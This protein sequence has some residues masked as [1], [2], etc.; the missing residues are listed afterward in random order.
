MANEVPA[1]NKESSIAGV[2]LSIRNIGFARR[3]PRNDDGVFLSMGN[4]ASGDSSVQITVLPGF[5]S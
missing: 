2:F 5:S 1:F 3:L 4:K